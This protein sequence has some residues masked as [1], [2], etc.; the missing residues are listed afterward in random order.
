MAQNELTNQESVATERFNLISSF[1]DESLTKKERLALMKARSLSEGPSLRTL[2]RYY[3]NFIAEGFNGLKPKSKDHSATQVISPEILKEATDARRENPQRSIKDI[4]YILEVSGKVPKDSV[5]RS[6][7]QRYFQKC[8][9]S[10]KQITNYTKTPGVA[11]RRYR[12]SHRMEQLQSDFKYA[13]YL[14]IGKG[15]KM[16]QTYYIGWIDNSSRMMLDGKFYSRQTFY[17]VEDSL[18]RV[19][20]QFGVPSTILLDNGKP[21]VSKKLDVICAKCNIKKIHA[22]P[23]S[24][25]TKG[26]IEVFN[27][28]LNKFISEAAIEKYETLEEL[29]LNYDAWINEYY[30][31]IPHAGLKEGTPISSFTNDTRPLRFISHSS[32]TDA[33]STRVTRKVKNDC[34]VSIDG[35]NYDIENPNLIGFEVV[36][37][38]DSHDLETITVRKVGY[39]D[40]IAKPLAIGP[41]VRKDK[42]ILS[43]SRSVKATTKS[44]LLEGVRNSYSMDNP[45]YDKNLA[46]KAVRRNEL[47]ATRKDDKS[48]AYSLSDA[49]E[50]N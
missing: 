26:L 23:Y 19:I 16:I 39:D 27:S 11:T 34:T 33:F 3:D 32:L 12:K 44:T 47:E 1:V 49:E 28:Y 18:K 35:I 37:I 50:T 15:H 20:M 48:F 24:P 6:T 22:K 5:K 9:F 45:D 36:V 8:G 40:I 29:N 41:F 38:Y 21:F 2:K 42:Q 43:K 30:N 46:E 7:L 14:P 4:I 13:S 17:E 31:S 10:K 25:Q